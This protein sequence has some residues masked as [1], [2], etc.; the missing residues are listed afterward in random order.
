MMK[1]LD[2]IIICDW[3]A[4]EVVRVYQR[5]GGNFELVRKTFQITSVQLKRL[6][7]QAGIERK[8]NTGLNEME[9][10]GLRRQD[11]I[12]ENQSRLFL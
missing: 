10:L 12:L 9:S 6:L 3:T 2:D 8:R 5:S 4:S 7:K 1:E 11:F